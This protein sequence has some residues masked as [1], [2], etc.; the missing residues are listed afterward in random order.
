MDKLFSAEIF[1][2]A[3]FLSTSGVIVVKR[4]ML[5]RILTIKKI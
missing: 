3:A 4:S 1:V 2:V 5:K